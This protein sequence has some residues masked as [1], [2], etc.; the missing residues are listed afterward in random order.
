MSIDIKTFTDNVAYRVKS[1]LDPIEQRIK[2][3]EERKPE[4]GEK[5][6]KGD[7]GET[8]T[9]YIEDVIPELVKAPEIIQAVKD[10]V[11]EQYAANPPPAGEKGEPGADGLGVTDFTINKEG[12]LIVTKTDGT[13]HNIGVVVGKDGADGLG[14]DK[15]ELE[16]D[17]E[18]G[19]TYRLTDGTRVLEKTIM[20]PIMEHKGFYEKGMEVKG[21]NLV[22]HNGS[23][24]IATKDTDEE[25]TYQSK[26]WH[27]AEREGRDGKIEYRLQ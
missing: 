17:S 7:P 27:L 3:L 5:G 15:A 6:D 16:Y 4:R 22:T 25:P 2:S 8:P 12:A 26:D 23:L 13:N 24:W 18:V 1:M 10:A 20:P 9:V 21:G 11:A 19:L 14:F